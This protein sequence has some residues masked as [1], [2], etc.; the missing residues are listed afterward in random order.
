MASHTVVAPFT[1]RFARLGLAVTGVLLIVGLSGCAGS[2][3]GPSSNYTGE[4][5]NPTVAVGLNEL[6]VGGAWLEDGGKF[7]I[8]VSGSSGCPPIAESYTITAHNEVAITLKEIP[9]DRVCTADFVP[10][11]SVF[12]TPTD[13]DPYEDLAMTVTEMDTTVILPGF[14]T[15]QQEE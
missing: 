5:Q 14:I 1:S 3:N 12:N 13:I 6:G 15:R 11:T 2:G 9:A 7:A 8:T 10:H 4:A